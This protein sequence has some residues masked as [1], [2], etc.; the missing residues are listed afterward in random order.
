VAPLPL[1]PDAQAALDL[2]KKAVP[3]GGALTTE[4]L[5]A[6]AYHAAA[7]DDPDQVPELAG[8]LPELTVQHADVPDTVSVD[9]GLRPLLRDLRGRD[10]INLQDLFL[11]MFDSAAATSYLTGH[12]MADAELSQVRARLLP[13][14]P[15]GLP[16]WRG[17]SERNELVERLSPWGRMLTVTQ[18]AAKG[19]MQM[20]THL[21]SLQ[22]NLLKMRRPNALI[23]GQPGTGKTALVYEFARLMIE[24]DPKIAPALLDRDVFELS[25]SLFRAGAGMVGE[26]EKRVGELIRIFEEHPQV[27]LFVD[28]IHSMLQ[29]GIHE[30][31]PFSQGDQAFK[32]AIGRGGFSLIGATTIAEYSHYIQPD[33]ALARR[34]GLLRI[35]PPTPTEALE[36]VRGRVEQYRAHYAPL[37]IPDE[38]LDKT[39]DLSESL[40]LTRF[41][42]DKSLDVLDE[43]CAVCIMED[44]PLEEVTEAVLME[45]IEDEIGHSVIKPGTLT[46]E[47]VFDRLHETI[48]GQ[49]EALDA[50]SRGFVSG[51]AENWLRHEGPRRIFFFCGPTGTGKTE[52]ARQLAKLLGGGREA[53]LRIDC[54]TLQGSGAE[55]PGPIINRLLGVPRGY[56]GYARG[57][58]GLLSKIRDTPEAIVLFDE[59]EKASPHIGKLLLQLLDE[60]KIEDVDG[61]RLDF[62]RAFVVFTTNAGSSYG[63]TRVI[64]PQPTVTRLADKTP[65]V[66]VEAVTEELRQAGYGEEFFGRHIDFVMFKGLTRD[67]IDEVLRRQMD[68]LKEAAKEHGFDLTWDDELYEHLLEEWTPR[69]GARWVQQVLSSRVD[70]QRRLAEI[71]GELGQEQEQMQDD[72]GRPVFDEQG[73]PVLV[74]VGPAVSRI[75][76]R[77]LP[78]GDEPVEDTLGRAMR[79]RKGDVLIIFVS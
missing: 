54:N 27:I 13:E 17:S 37:R 77:L 69:Y 66:T 22:K 59:I 19:V 61:N 65:T 55:D 34:F 63:A 28:E 41:Q 12:G 31:G 5:L 21:R 38:I 47:S 78:R 26:Y 32:Q 48:L 72:K 29:S 68:G 25:V 51:L 79:R 62:R 73:N 70:E 42:P 24:Q 30:S 60:G 9:E 40:L 50:I 16:A 1:T 39:V 2:A 67:V 64:G 11:A 74:T 36:I 18:P 14:A 10:K 46:A 15:V 53:M 71:E 23:I 4:L 35:E 75:E 58:G 8:Y 57:E 3:E 43:A 7:L 76:L 56:I 45:A 52:T 33:G 44:P 6:A 49:D 20:D